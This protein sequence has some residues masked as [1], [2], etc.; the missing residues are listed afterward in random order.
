MTQQEK[1]F[2]VQRVQRIPMVST[3]LEVICK[4]TGMGFAA[5][6]RV[7]ENNWL[8]CSVRDEINFGL[9]PGGELEIATTI[10]NEIRQSRKAV[11]INHVTENE[12]FCSH[13]TPAMY[14][15][16]SY[17]SVPIILNDGEMFGTLCAIDPRPAD[18]ENKKTIGM[19]QLFAQLLAF[20]LQT[21]DELEESNKSI[22]ALNTELAHARD[23]NRQYQYISSHNLQEPLRKLRI[24]SSLLA[25]SGGDDNRTRHLAEKI[26]SSAQRFSMMIKDLSEFSHLNDIKG[27]FEPVNLN[28]VITDVC[29]QLEEQV[30]FQ[31]ARV[32]T[33]TLPVIPG[34]TIQLEQL[35]FHLIH[36]SLK[37]AQDGRPPVITINAAK[38]DQHQITGGPDTGKEFLHIAY[39]DNG[40]GIDASQLERV[41]DMFS[42]LDA[43]HDFKSEGIGLAYCR[44]IIRNHGGTITAKSQPGKGT[45]FHILLPLHATASADVE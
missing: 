34:I 35:F 7:T 26:N 31:H 2:A 19:F 6:A 41:F 1:N 36:N 28:Q 16:Q 30:H 11:V 24:F 43:S 29:L 20:H 25:E 14:G 23:E 9:Q 17:I 42:K 40:R 39:A 4:S 10:C 32:Q 18:V 44:K 12:F 13:P 8:A 45:T 3:M 5:V 22:Q 27:G 37:F 15:F 33:E 21:V 38:N